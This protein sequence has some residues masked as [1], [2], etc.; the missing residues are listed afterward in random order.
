MSKRYVLLTLLLQVATMFSSQAFAADPP[1]ADYDRA[2]A[3]IKEGQYYLKTEV[4]GEALYVDQSGYVVNE[5]DYACLF[6]IS[7]ATGGNLYN[8]GILIDPNN[9]SHFSNP[10]LNG[11][12]ADLAYDHFKQEPSGGNNRSNWE[13]Q[14]FFMNTEGLFAIRSCNTTYAETSWEDAG[15]TFWSYE[16]DDD[17]YFLNSCYSY[18]PAYVWQLELP[19]DKVAIMAILEGIFEVYGDYFYDEDGEQMGI[20][21]GVNQYSDFES[22]ETFMALLQQVD[23][24]LNKLYDDSYDPSTDPD[25]LT[26]ESAQAIRTQLD[27][28]YDAIIESRVPYPLPNGNGYYRIIANNRYVSVDSETGFVDKAIAA[29]YSEEH[30]NKGVYATL[31]RDRANFLWKLEQVGDSVNIQNAGLGNYIHPSSVANDRV[32]LTDSV[33]RKSAIVL[34]LAGNEYVESNTEQGDKDILYIRLASSKN[35]DGKFIHQ[36]GHGQQNADT[37]SGRAG[38]DSGTEKELSF[39]VGTIEMGGDKGT[40]EWYLEYVPDDEAEAIIASFNGDKD[41]DIL[42]DQN[43]ALRAEV[44][45]SITATKDYIAEELIK[46]ASQLS[47]D[48]SQNDLGDTD[49]GNLSDGVTIDRNLGTFWHSY[50]QGG[51]GT[52]LRHYIVIADMDEMVGNCQLY[53]GWRSAGNDLPNRLLFQGSEDPYADDEDWADIIELNLPGAASGAEATVPFYVE[54]GYPY[55]RVCA[56]NCT[57]SFRGYWHVAELQISRL[58]DNPNSQFASLG[59]VATTLEELYNANVATADEDITQEQYDALLAAYKAFMEAMVDPTELRNAIA[60]YSNLSTSVV[61]GEGPGLW[62]DTSIAEQFDELLDEA[63]TYDESGNYTAEQTHLYALM[64][65]AMAKSVRE[66]ANGVETDK[67]Y[68]IMFPT[69]DLYDLYGF[70]KSGAGKSGLIEDQAYQFGNF[71]TS[72]ANIAEE[73]SAP[74]DENPDAVVTERH[75]EA[76]TS[77]EVRESNGLYF[78]QEDEIVDE[79]AS[80]FRFVEIEDND[81]D[82][83]ALLQDVKENMALALD[84]ATSYTRGE[85]LI[86]DVAQLSS[87]ATSTAEGTL[88]ALID[89]NTATYW[90]SDY[91]RQVL[92]PHYLQVALN[93]PVSGFIQVDIARRNAGN[94]HIVRMYVQ[95]SNDAA[96]WTNIGYIETPYTNVNEVSSSQ[97]LDLGGTYSYLRFI[98]TYRYGTDGGGNTEFDPFAEITS[99]DEY[100]ILWTYCHASE[101]QIYPLTEAKA[102]S[103]NAQALRDAFTAANKVVFKD[104][105]A[106]DYA[107]AANG[108][109]G[110][111]DEYNAAAG[112][113]VL[114]DGLAKAPATYAIQSKATGLFVNAAGANSN[115][116]YLRTIPTLFTYSAPGYQRSLLHGK[117][118]DGT[119]CSYLH[120]QNADH[121]LV[122]WNATAPSSNSGLVLL[123]AEDEEYEAPAEFTFYKDIKPGQINAW[124]NSVQ[125]TPEAYDD[126][127]AYTSLGRFY[128]EDEGTFL[129]LKQ[130]ETIPAGEP[131]IYILSDTLNYIAEEEDA[132][133]IAFT[134]PGNAEIALEALSVNGLQGELSNRALKPEEIYFTA[135]YAVCNDA[136]A[137]T[138][139]FGAASLNLDYAPNFDPN[140]DYDIAIYLGDAADKADAVENIAE[141]IEKVSKSGDVY[142]MDGKLLM[143]N[144]TL[145][146][147][148]T[149]GRGMYILGG[150]KVLVK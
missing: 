32:N 2:M 74:T 97:P 99:P 71:V 95:G 53:F 90:H 77:E 92:E 81:A 147:V 23:E 149:L 4:N 101:F 142:S 63:K 51:E 88:A 94:G 107:N 18:E 37:P 6:T 57:P 139:P 38:T 122:T 131:A 134:I 7:K 29:S 39:W 80:L 26:V 124:T 106:E 16:V 66:K 93:E 72:G 103:A 85:A 50:W 42:V 61:E 130:I 144:G 21:T 24:A 25:G 132:E 129:A 46:S 48:Y 89:G 22:W 10:P 83:T 148:K 111:K 55:V 41:H 44:L 49:G 36:L 5:K 47:S 110:Y 19:A 15:R 58:Y 114:P 14:V 128:V 98:L 138:I 28:L 118:V 17:G 100:N 3:N 67:W 87:N 140:G 115:G 112:K 60:A 102:L 79:N 78:V 86:T 75:I 62:S 135:N 69:E 54:Q 119:D 150:V 40:S 126:A 76:L 65:K 33:E 8:E 64:L 9:G 30:A 125:V 127:Y 109:K 145:N 68:R 104:A 141:A 108:Y 59:A 70:D 117:K 45:A 20:G 73:V 12:Y 13:R 1:Q 136:S 105:T 146:S 82:F 11:N 121:R 34:L 31:Q 56:T 84:M 133:P 52:D 35:S 116:V 43:N 137:Y 27:A 96:A 113:N 123:E 91:A 143:K 120:S